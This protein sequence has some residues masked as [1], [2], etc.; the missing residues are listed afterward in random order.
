[1]LGDLRPLEMMVEAFIGK[2]GDKK[3]PLASPLFADLKGLPP[4]LLQVGTAEVLL[5][6]STR[7]AERASAAGV[8]VPLKT[9]EDMFHVWHAFADMLPEGME[10]TQEL[11]DFV[12]ARMA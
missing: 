8:D 6:D 10:A 4:L 3:A 1:M 9:W 7:L 5:D 12:N 2:D 11:A